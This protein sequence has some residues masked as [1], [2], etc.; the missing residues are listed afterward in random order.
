MR[1]EGESGRSA[2]ARR[3]HQLVTALTSEGPFDA[4]LFA[5]TSSAVA[6]GLAVY[7]NGYLARLREALADN[8]GVFARA[9]GDDGFA[10]LADRYA[11]AHPPVGT[12]LR[13]H[14]D[15]LVEFL[16]D[17]SRAEGGH[18]LL[19]H[20]ALLDLARMD[21]ALR[22]AFDAAD[23]V[24][25]S[26]AELQALP[27]QGWPGLRLRLLPSARR[28]RLEWA[29]ESAWHLLNRAPAGSEPR[30]PEPHHHEHAVLVWR[31]GAENLWRSLDEQEN[32][33]LE[34][35]ERE[36]SLGELGEMLAR[37]LGDGTEAGARLVG[38]LQQWLPEGCVVRA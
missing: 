20:P 25:F 18:G 28:I 11:R 34:R 7:R 2:L 31:P 23:C 1:P 10:D 3:Q 15:R 36:C 14:G 16:A 17:H 5:G 30:L 4:T 21:R 37:S 13:S 6:R 32:A 19:P 29:V 38:Y 27:P 35:L 12:S 8:Y 9:L 26:A 33:L 24:P 22:D